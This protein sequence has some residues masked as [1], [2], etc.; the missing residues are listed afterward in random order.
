[1]HVL[2]GEKEDENNRC[3]VERKREREGECITS[4]WI[5]VIIITIKMPGV[6]TSQPQTMRNLN[7]GVESDDRR[8]AA[9][10]DSYFIDTP[11]ANWN[12]QQSTPS[13]ATI[14]QQAQQVL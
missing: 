11:S 6:A 4:K 12:Q 10:L 8:I 3:V 9:L 5:R 1:M 2:K 7:A 14:G 13:S